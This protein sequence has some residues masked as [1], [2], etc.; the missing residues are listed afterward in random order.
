MYWKSEDYE[1]MA[2]LVIEIYLDYG[3]TTFPIDEKEICKKMG[4][5]LLP[6]TEFPKEVSDISNDA[7]LF[8]TKL[9]IMLMG[10]LKNVINTMKIWQIF[11][12]IYDVSYSNT[13][14]KKTMI[15]SSPSKNDR[16]DYL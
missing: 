2:K 3:I 14:Q 7:F 9:S 15:N 4:I 6:Y 13:Y 12:K 10:I 5:L 8:F 1:E 11:F 16:K